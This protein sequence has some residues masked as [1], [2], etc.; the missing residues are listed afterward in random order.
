M[1]P[2]PC[3]VRCKCTN[4]GTRLVEGTSDGVG[5]DARDGPGILMVREQV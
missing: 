3:G 1:L 2:H 5:D 4:K